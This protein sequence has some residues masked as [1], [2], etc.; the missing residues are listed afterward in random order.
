[1][2]LSISETASLWL[3]NIKPSVKSST[4][5]VYGYALTKH[6]LPYFGNLSF[7]KEE[8]INAFIAYKLDNGL[9]MKSIIDLL[10]VLRMICK[11]GERKKHLSVSDWRI[12]VKL[13]RAN[14]K[15]EVL[16]FKNYTIL[17][18]HVSK[19]ISLK[20]LGIYISLCTGLR[21]GEVCGLKWCDIDILEGTLSINRT[22][23]R[24]YI[25]SDVPPR[26]RL[27]ISSPKTISSHRV[28]PLPGSLLLIL[29]KMKCKHEA[30][31]YVVTGTLKPTEPRSYRNYYYS[32][33]KRLGL[34]R[35]KF[36]ALRHSFATLCVDTNQD[37]KVL[38]SIMGH[39]DIVTTL[40]LYVHPGLEQKRRCIDNLLYGLLPK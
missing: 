3:D 35:L 14:K 20:N 25:A 23:E 13:Y 37:Y 8:D 39:S 36:H 4:L 16:S 10:V 5:S 12:P 22:V 38:S 31:C 2:E 21:I 33:C 19:N 24:L 18:D 26:T 28:I 40:N 27:I 6:I 7:I 30:N 15:L 9:S 11:F 1:M 32:I 17:L 29:R 34:P